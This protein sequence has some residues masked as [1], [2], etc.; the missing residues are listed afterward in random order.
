MLKNAFLRTLPLGQKF[1]LD[2]V[3]YK[4]VETGTDTVKC[5]DLRF[6][7]VW[8]IKGNAIVRAVMRDLAAV[9]R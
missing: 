9:T 7:L 2:N 8:D 4:V 1:Y 5:R 6:K 3:L